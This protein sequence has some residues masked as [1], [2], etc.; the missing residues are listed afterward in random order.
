MIIVRFTSGLGNQMFQYNLYSLFKEMYPQTPVKADVRWFYTQD[1]HHGFELRRIFENVKGSSFSLE[2]ASTREIYTVSGQIPTPVK[3]TLAPTIKH[4]LGPVNRKLREA[5]KP[6]KNGITFDQL[7]APIDPD[8]LFNLDPDR[9][10]YI[11]GY[12]VEEVYYKNR[13]D[14]LK[15]E[16]VFP[17]LSGENA[18]LAEKMQHENSVSVHV[19]RGDYLSATYLDKFISLGMDYYEAAVDVIK[20]HMESPKFYI[21]SE[22]PDYTRQAFDWLADKTI[23]DINN[24]DDSYRDM[25]LMTK[26]KANITANST[27]SQWASI[28]NENSDHITVYPAKYMADEDT[29]I[30]KM[31][32]WIRI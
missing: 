6:E 16:L 4:L 31:P 26:C 1:E 27:F 17:E 15:K 18:D 8:D 30:R 20:Q 22:D 23:V 9:N 28:L 13:V 12:F 7:R 10:Y 29:E 2:E 11:F 14:A 21:F 19:R 32:G 5:G 3:G 25:Q 24:G